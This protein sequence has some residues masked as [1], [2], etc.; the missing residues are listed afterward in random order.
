MKLLKLFENTDFDI[1]GDHESVFTTSPAARQQEEQ[2]QRE[3]EQ[4]RQ[5]REVRDQQRRE[6]IEQNG[7]PESIPV[8]TP[9]G[10][11]FAITNPYYIEGSGPNYAGSADEFFQFAHTTQRNIVR[12]IDEALRRNDL[13][14]LTIYTGGP[15]HTYVGVGASGRLTW[16]KYDPSPGAGQNWMYFPNSGRVNT[17]GFINMSEQDQDTLMQQCRE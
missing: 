6:E 2:H 14:P 13:A 4:L 12:N 10:R 9:N 8:V 5:Q 15:R 3:Q 16:R 7:I 17:S 1:F 11:R